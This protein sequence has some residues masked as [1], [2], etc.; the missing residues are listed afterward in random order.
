MVQLNAENLPLFDMS[1]EIP[2]PVLSAHMAEESVLEEPILGSKLLLGAPSAEATVPEPC[3]F[4]PKLQ[5]EI[6]MTEMI[7]EKVQHDATTLGTDLI[8][9][10]PKAVTKAA[11]PV[12]ELARNLMNGT[13]TTQDKDSVAHNRRAPEAYVMPALQEAPLRRSARTSATSDEHTLDKVE[14]IAT[15]RNLEA[16]GTTNSILS[17]SDSHIA[18]NMRNLGVNAG[19]DADSIKQSVISIK[20]NA[21]IDRFAARGNKGGSK[22]NNK[23]NKPITMHYQ[24]SALCRV[25]EGLPSAIPRA[26]TTTHDVHKT[27]GKS[28]LCRVL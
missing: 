26:L 7:Q 22:N 10:S 13:A 15:I 17:L 6:P 8:Q 23:N 18:S 16:K 2:E 5:S 25:P 19:N 28:L 14:R 20:K 27:L 12:P 3:A 11:A 9:S 4:G 24:K 1:I 21:E